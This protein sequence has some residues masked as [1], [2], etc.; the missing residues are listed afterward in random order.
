MAGTRT[1]KRSAVSFKL[2]FGKDA[3]DN[4]IIKSVALQD[5]V[6]SPDANDIISIS[7]ALAPCLEK[8][9]V[10]IEHTRVDLITEV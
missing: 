3:K 2:N 1:L 7:K 5:V 4:D 10:R 6:G 9:M 8:E